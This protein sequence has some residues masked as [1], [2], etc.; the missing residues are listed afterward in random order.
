MA[1][2]ADTTVMQ[3]FL[4]DTALPQQLSYTG[5]GGRNRVTGTVYTA[6]IFSRQIYI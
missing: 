1:I 6:A 5:T 3:Q 4:A 2:L